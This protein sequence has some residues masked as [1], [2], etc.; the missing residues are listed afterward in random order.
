MD[1]RNKWWWWW[2]LLNKCSLYVNIWPGTDIESHKGSCA[3]CIWLSCYVD[4]VCY[5]Y[6]K[7]KNVSELKQAPH[8][9]SMCSIEGMAPCIHNTCTNWSWVVS[10]LLQSLCFGE[11]VHCTQQIRSLVGTR[12]GLAGFAEQKGQCPSTGIE[13][14]FPDHPVHSLVIVQS[15]QAWLSLVLSVYYLFY[16]FNSSRITCDV[17]E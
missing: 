9:E 10:L 3:H 1:L 16:L 17:V 11:G 14:R 8:H 15:E 12:A 6:G 13:S 5:H 4:I 2:W 7:G